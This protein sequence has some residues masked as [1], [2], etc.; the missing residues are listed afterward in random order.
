MSASISPM[1]QGTARSDRPFVDWVTQWGSAVVDGII[2]IGDVAIFTWSM[3][4]WMFTRLPRRGTVL[5]NFYQVGVRSLPVV[6]LTGTF[7]GMVLAERVFQLSYIPGPGLWL[8]GTLVGAIGVGIAGTLG[9]RSTL[10]H[11]PLQTL[12]RL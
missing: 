11:P 7:I 9:T 10:H 8:G 5:I 2:R 4:Q 3:C 12:R 1:P 6:A